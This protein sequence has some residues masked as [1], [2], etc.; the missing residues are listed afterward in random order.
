MSDLSGLI[1]A[2]FTPFNAQG[3]V[4]YS[5]VDELAK[6]YQSNG[7]SG[8]FIIGTTGEC[9]SLTHQEKKKM[10]EMWARAK[11]GLK[12]VSMIG[13]SC[14]EDMKDLA[15]HSAQNGLDAIAMLPPYYFKLKDESKLVEFCAQVAN[16]S[17]L[18]LYFYHIPSMTNGHFKMLKFLT[19]VEK[20]LPNFA[21]IKFSHE[22]LL[23]FQNCTAYSDGKFNML[24]GIDEALLSGLVAGADGAVG[25]TYN[26]AAPLYCMLLEDL[27]RG[28]LK[29]AREKQKKAVSMVN[30][31]MKYGGARAGK[32]FM[33][34]I[35]LDCGD[36]RQP[37]TSMS[38]SEISKMKDELSLI[39]FS[40][41]AS[42]PPR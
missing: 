2:P 40:E 12:V 31:L 3:R 20:A 14:L 29:C 23:D 42:K 24:W 5:K 16:A 38:K 9:A 7:V 36:N 4:D 28:D 26:Y 15:R 32:G 8:A 11:G 27:E 21:G 10:I 39:G 35:G 13:G 22:D 25:S 6:L 30:I 17:D 1:A 37:L 19:L 34:I 41:F 18:P 33:K